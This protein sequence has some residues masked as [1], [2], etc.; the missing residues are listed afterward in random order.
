MSKALAETEDGS[1]RKSLVS[2]VM[3]EKVGVKASSLDIG[4]LI[5]GI[6][7]ASSST[8]PLPNV[9]FPE[10]LE[11]I[12]ALLGDKEA[13]IEDMTALLQS[14]VSKR[15]DWKKYAHFDPCRVRFL[16]N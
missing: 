1:C 10:L 8:D 16:L 7:K 2:T 12:D 14:Y 5:N 4:G 6:P 15:S 11:H 9:T 3:L 13:C